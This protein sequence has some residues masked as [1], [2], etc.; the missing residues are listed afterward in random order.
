MCAASKS[1]KNFP[2]QK[3]VTFTI[4]H[5]FITSFLPKSPPGFMV[6]T[7][8]KFAAAFISST[9]PRSPLPFSASTRD[10]SVSRTLVA[11]KHTIKGQ[12]LCSV[13]KI[14]WWQIYTQR[15]FSHPKKSILFVSLP[16]W[17]SVHQD[18]SRWRF[19]ITLVC[20]KDLHKKGN[21]TWFH[22]SFFLLARGHRR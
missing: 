17:L 10:F 19:P 3:T 12:S 5:H 9:S 21:F 6:A 20:L 8:R 22:L 18:I 2:I 13:F 16:G 11:N 1:N 7:R 14:K 15:N 4:L